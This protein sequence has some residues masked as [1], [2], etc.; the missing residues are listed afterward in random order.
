MSTPEFYFTIAQPSEA[1]FKDRGSKFIANAFPI[2]TVD[3]FRKMLED[4][5]KTHSKAT[6]HCFAYRLGT[7]K[8]VYRVSDD[9]EPS[10]TAGMPILG[11][12]DSKGLTDTLVIVT[13]YFGGSLLGVPGLINAYKMAASMALQITP[14]IKKDI[15]VSYRL[16]FDYTRMNEVMRVLKQ[17]GGRII[18]QEMQ[19][20]SVIVVALPVKIAEI[21]GNELRDIPGMEMSKI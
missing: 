21:T 8:N 13:R 20:F 19:L 4:I 18:S 14:V 1:E 16:H 9:G 6:H 11:Q 15:E 7:D 12:I 17:R 5:R 2:A 3:D 10:R